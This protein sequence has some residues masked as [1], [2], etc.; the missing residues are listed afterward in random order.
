MVRY[1]ILSENEELSVRIYDAPA[2]GWRILFVERDGSITKYVRRDHALAGI[3]IY[4]HPDKTSL[5]EAEIEVYLDAARTGKALGE[6][7]LPS[8]VRFEDMGHY[9]YATFTLPE[10]FIRQSELKIIGY[11]REEAIHSAGWGA[12]QLQRF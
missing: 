11:K 10:D 3:E 6:C 1:E 4:D 7:G 5:F 9:T 12:N 2:C 8:L